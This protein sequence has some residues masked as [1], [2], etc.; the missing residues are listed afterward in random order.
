M[1]NAFGD[2]C[3]MCELDSPR[4]CYVGNIK[5]MGVC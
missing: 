2:E 5:S 4:F 3:T 1:S